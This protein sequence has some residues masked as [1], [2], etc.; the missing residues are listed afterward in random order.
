MPNLHNDQSEFTMI[1]FNHNTPIVQALFPEAY[2]N[3]FV[4][5]E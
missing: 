3:R 2:Y 4:G 5:D 1:R